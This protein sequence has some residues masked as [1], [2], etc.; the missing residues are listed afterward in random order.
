M[1]TDVAKTIIASLAEN[2]DFH[3]LNRGLLFSAESV[4]YDNRDETLTVEM[5]NDDI[6][7]N[8]DGGHTM[9]ALFQAQEQ[10][11]DL[12]FRYVFAEIFVGI[13]SPV[14]LAAAR[15]TSVQVDLK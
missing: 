9:R 5:N 12:D 4:S 8:I 11:T 1:T 10:G 13:T 14:E 3:E 2:D 15:N 7:G 6:H